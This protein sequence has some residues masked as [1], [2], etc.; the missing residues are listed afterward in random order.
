MALSLIDFQNLFYLTVQ[1][2][3]AVPQPLGQIFMHRRFGDP[4]LLCRSADGG[5]VF[6]D[7]HGQIAGPFFHVVCQKATL[8]AHRSMA[9]YARTRKTMQ[10]LD[11]R[12]AFHTLILSIAV[13]TE[14]HKTQLQ[15]FLKK[16]KPKFFPIGK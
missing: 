13:P 5:A 8:P 2:N 6:D 12:S 14:D 15:S 4:E 10:T 3:I 9:M 7:V 1:A 11:N 16:H